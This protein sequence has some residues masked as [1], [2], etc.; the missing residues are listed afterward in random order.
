VP[1]KPEGVSLY[2]KFPFKIVGKHD[3]KLSTDFIRTSMKSLHPDETKKLAEAPITT[4]LLHS[5]ATPP[6]LRRMSRDNLLSFSKSKLRE[7]ASKHS[8]SY[9]HYTEGEEDDCSYGSSSHDFI[10]QEHV[11][12]KLKNIHSCSFKSSGKSL[13]VTPSLAP[14]I[15]TGVT[16]I[17]A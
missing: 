6:A 2:P 10:P 12:D 17:A 5:F 15:T 4:N 3:I 16:P 7:E 11:T 9:S 14:S 13:N 1:V 8:G